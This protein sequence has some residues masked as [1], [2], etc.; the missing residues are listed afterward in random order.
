MTIAIVGKFYT[1]GTG[2]HLA[3]AIE[4]LGHR[5]LKIDPEINLTEAKFFS[6]RMRNVGITLYKDVLSKLPSVRRFNSKR[7][8]NQIKSEKIDLIISLHDYLTREEVK[9][10]KEIINSPVCIWFPDALV[11]LKKSMF[12]YADYDFL[13]FKDLYLVEL[14]KV[15]FNLNAHYLPQCCNPVKHKII[16]LDDVE[17]EMYTCQ[18][19]NA[20]NIYPSRAALLSQL[21][22]Y[23]TIKF[24]G[25]LPAVW[26]NVP[27]LDPIVMGRVIYNTEKGKA[28]GAAKV[29]LNNLHPTEVN[30][31][32]KRSFEVAACGGFQITNLKPCTAELFEIDKEIVCY[33]TFGELKEKLDYYVD[34]RNDVERRNI[35]TAGRERVV[36]EHT[37]AHR[38]NKMLEI[39]FN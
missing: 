35:I 24:W 30:G 7:I 11:N 23:Y 17:K 9:T 28:F 16:E 34:D 15:E 4:L 12:F 36:K 3:E 26:L 19:T 31:L 1:E 39:V 14:A 21:M 33:T 13:F 5:V 22:P 25:G 38:F 29:V 32:N 2:L 37:Y 18:I 10:M 27:E 6:Q 8:Y 20:G